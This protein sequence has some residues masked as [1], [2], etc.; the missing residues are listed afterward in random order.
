MKSINKTAT[1]YFF[2]N[3]LGTRTLIKVW[4]SAWPDPENLKSYLALCYTLRKR[5]FDTRIG[6]SW[7]D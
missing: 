4:A 5:G 3:R 1:M 7:I 6:S 2:W